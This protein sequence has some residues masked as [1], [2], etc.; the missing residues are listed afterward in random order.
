[1]SCCKRSSGVTTRLLEQ[2]HEKLESVGLYYPGTDVSCIIN[3]AGEIVAQNEWS[4]LED[5]ELRLVVASLK[6]AALQFGQSLGETDIPIVH[7]RATSHMFSAYDI[8]EHVLAFFTHMEPSSIQLFDT[9]RADA[10]MEQLL[11]EL[12]LLL[13]N[14]FVSG[15]SG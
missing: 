7:I 2:I 15:Y 13:H 11:E 14:A 1:M 9:S 12:K 10:E 6:R 5:D 3:A 4:K 8:G